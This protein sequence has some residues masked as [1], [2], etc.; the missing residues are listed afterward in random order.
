MS[1]EA[2]QGSAQRFVGG[3]FGAAAEKFGG[4]AGQAEFPRGGGRAGNRRGN[5][6]PDG[7]ESRQ[8][9]AFAGDGTQ[10]GYLKAKSGGP[11]GAVGDQDE[12]VRIEGGHHEAVAKGNRQ[13]LLQHLPDARQFNGA[14]LQ[15]KEPI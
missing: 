11:R 10:R 6:D 3:G 2:E 5:P 12:G 14:L 9:A 7:L 8:S 13:D 1:G 4:V 15:L